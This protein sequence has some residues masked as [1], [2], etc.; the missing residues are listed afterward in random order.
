[1]NKDYVFK[2]LSIEEQETLN[3]L[4]VTLS[5]TND[6]TVNVV[7]KKGSD[8]FYIDIRWAK[9]KSRY[10]IYIDFDVHTDAIEEF[11]LFIMHG[12]RNER[13]EMNRTNETTIL[14]VLEK[15]KIHI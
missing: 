8:F 10:F 12:D 2:K 6:Y 14:E 11:G 1:M 7:E 5:L 3:A 15:V 9:N 4:F 13:I